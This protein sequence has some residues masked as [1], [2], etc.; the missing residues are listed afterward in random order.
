[1]GVGPK[2]DPAVRYDKSYFLQGL[3]RSKKLFHASTGKGRIFETLVG[4]RG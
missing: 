1:M 2:E 4:D 3:L